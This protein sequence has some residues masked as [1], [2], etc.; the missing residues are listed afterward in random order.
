[1]KTPLFS[2]CYKKLNYIARLTFSV[3]LYGLQM[4][5]SLVNPWYTHHRGCI[6]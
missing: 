2:G 3:L 4:D 6:K 1:M 5:A